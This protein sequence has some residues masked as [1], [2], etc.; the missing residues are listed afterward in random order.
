[1]PNNELTYEQA[2]Q[3]LQTIVRALQ[4]DTVSV[5]D[6]TEKSRRAA[7]L[8]RYCQEKLRITEAEVKN[9]FQE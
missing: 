3:E 8:I 5:D 9:L 6:L 1:M 4:E 7:E 2:L